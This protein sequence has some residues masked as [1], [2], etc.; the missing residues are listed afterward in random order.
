MS[1]LQQGWQRG[2]LDDLDDLEDPAAAR[3]VWSGGPPGPAA[4][5]SDGEAP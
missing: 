2:R 1:A 5:P 4:D 3:D